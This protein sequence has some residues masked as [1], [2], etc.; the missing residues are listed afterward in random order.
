MQNSMPNGVISPK[1]SNRVV[2]QPNNRTL[3]ISGRHAVHLERPANRPPAGS[4]SQAVSSRVQV[5]T[6]TQLTLPYVGSEPQW[7]PHQPQQIGLVRSLSAA[8]AGTNRRAH[9]S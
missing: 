7:G 5:C 1:W 8:Q 9:A 4:L 3:K 6:A 2:D